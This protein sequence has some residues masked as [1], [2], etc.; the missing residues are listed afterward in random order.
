MGTDLDRLRPTRELPGVDGRWARVWLEP[1]DNQVFVSH[2]EEHRIPFGIDTGDERPAPASATGADGPECAMAA[3][4]MLL[5]GGT[6]A[7]TSCPS[8]ALSDTDAATLAD[9]VGFLAG[10]DLDYVR[11]V[12]DDSAR[13]EQAASVVEEA[14]SDAELDVVLGEDQVPGYGAV[15]AVSGWAEASRVLSRHTELAQRRPVDVAGA[16]LAPWLLNPAVL[17]STPAALLPLGFDVRSEDPQAFATALRRALP[18]AS[19]TEAAYA[20]WAAGAE[21]EAVRIFA[22]SP[23][24]VPMG[25]DHVPPTVGWLP[26]GTVTP[27]TPPLTDVTTGS[28][29]PDA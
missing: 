21:P 22:A 9:S 3:V 18:D 15:V 19:P 14:A 23:V 11:L 26:G 24:S 17:R 28:S 8:D 20:T 25:H 2:G 4:G 5:A 12:A 10:R 29:S 13:S 7:V 1:G 6:S 27:V 16:Y